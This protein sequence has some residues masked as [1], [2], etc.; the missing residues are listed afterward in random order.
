MD[1]SYLLFLQKI[2]ETAPEW[3]NSFMMLITDTAGGIFI[4]LIPMIVFFC[5][6]KKRGEF[7]WFSLAIASVIN[8]F[9]KNIF[10][11][12][13]PWIRSE[14]IKPASGAI[15]GAGDY[16]F[17]SSHTQ[18]S[19]SAFGAVAFVYRKRKLLSIICICLVLLVA[20]SR[21]YLGVH[22][23]QDVLAGM[24]I[25]IAGIFFAYIIQSKIEGS[26]KNRRTFYRT[27]V[28]VIIAA[29]IFVCTKNYP[30]DY[31]ANGHILYDPLHSIASFASKAGL[32]IGFLTAWILEEKYIAFS[33]DNLSTKN[34]IIRLLVGIVLF[35]ISA[36]LAAGVS[37]LLPIAWMSAFAQNALMYFCINFFGP[38]IFSKIESRR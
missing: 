31:D 6:D 27:A 22:T 29:L 3:F 10:C 37:S 12:Y 18:G 25:A 34:R 30:I 4:L 5:I 20:F 19:A 28:I 21:N 26:E 7:I 15:E 33:T 11:V 35:F 8:V 2:R 13:R 9:I 36:I 24:L 17:P 32:A 1:I 16:S 23:P 14:L 38:L